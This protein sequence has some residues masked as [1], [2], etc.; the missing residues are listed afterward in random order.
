[1]KKNF[2]GVLR[3]LRSSKGIAA[4]GGIVGVIL[5]HALE[6]DPTF[7]AELRPIIVTLVLAFIG[8][9]VAEDV[10]TKL[11]KG[12]GDANSG[13]DGGGSSG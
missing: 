11:R 2:S 7:A 5:T 3:I 8:G 4:I 9:N 13:S 6:M 12:G 1:M 10:A